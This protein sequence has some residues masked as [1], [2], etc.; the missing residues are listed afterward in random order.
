MGL[1]LLSSRAFFSVCLCIVS[2]NR[3]KK[4]KTTPQ[5][6][7]SITLFHVS[8]V[9][10]VFRERSFEAFSTFERLFLRFGG[11]ARRA[12]LEVSWLL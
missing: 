9:L 7:D 4:N 11:L 1:S 6:K 12:A 8:Q 3:D 5:A 2:Q 10:C